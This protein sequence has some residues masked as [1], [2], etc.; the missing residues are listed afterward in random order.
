[1]ETNE[2][3]LKVLQNPSTLKRTIEALR[4]TAELANDP[5]KME[6]SLAIFQTKVLEASKAF[7]ATAAEPDVL[8]LATKELLAG[9][10]SNVDFNDLA[11]LKATQDSITEVWAEWTEEIAQVCVAAYVAQE[12][13]ISSAEGET[14]LTY[15]TIFGLGKE[16]ALYPK[17]AKLSTAKRKSLGAKAFCGP[18]RSFPVHDRAHAIAALRLLGRYK[19]PGDKSTIRACIM[20]KA[21]KFGVGPGAKEGSVQFFP[22]YLECNDGVTGQVIID[23]VETCTNTKADLGAISEHY[24]LTEEQ[25]GQ[26]K[27]LFDEFEAIIASVT[28]E[29]DDFVPDALFEGNGSQTDAIALGPEFLYNYFVR[30]QESLNSKALLMLVGIAKKQNLTKS[31]LEE[32]SE[33]YRFFNTFILGRLADALPEKPEQVQVKQVQTTDEVVVPPQEKKPENGGLFRKV[34][35]RSTRKGATN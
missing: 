12:G 27:T 30:T 17:E 20:R 28:L 32:A 13:K 14:L 25:V 8:E 26:L 7:L 1:M 35:K 16:D 9:E 34:N 11:L 22:L 31:E 33:Q 24:E 2:T 29:G 19:G 23:S 4:E 21:A 5:V 6:E 18:N 15:G 10:V 3:Y